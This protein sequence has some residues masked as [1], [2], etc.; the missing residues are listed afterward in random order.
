M[1][2]KYKQDPKPEV[3]SPGKFL[4]AVGGMSG[5]VLTFFCARYLGQNSWTTTLFCAML[6]CVVC[7]LFMKRLAV[8]IESNVDRIRKEKYMAERARK[9]AQEESQMRALDE[10]ESRDA[11]NMLK[12]LGGKQG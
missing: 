10:E 11:T 5:F 9:R 3:E 4:I 6:A 8:Y 1:A 7:G 12:E 2:K